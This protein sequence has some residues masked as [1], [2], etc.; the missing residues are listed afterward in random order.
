MDVAQVR[1]ASHLLD[2][3]FP[4][5][6]GP[7]VIPAATRVREWR[8]TSRVVHL[9]LAH[10]L[11]SCLRL[12]FKVMRDLLISVWTLFFVCHPSEQLTLTSSTLAPR[13]TRSGLYARC[14]CI[15]PQLQ[16]QVPHSES[17]VFPIRCSRSLTVYQ[18][19]RFVTAPKFLIQ[20]SVRSAILC[21]SGN[22]R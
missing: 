4:L 8:S 10:R 19:S 17:T 11:T 5:V 15:T 6:S 12:A 7:P 13:P 16:S 14:V 2:S 9:V 20:R 18:I 1:R 3:L 21:V 22:L